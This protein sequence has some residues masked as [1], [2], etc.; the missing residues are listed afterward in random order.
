MGTDADKDNSSRAVV[1]IRQLGQEDDAGDVSDR[2]PEERFAMMWQ[3]A[4][5]AWAFKG[6]PVHELRL[7]RHVRA[8][9]EEAGESLRRVGSAVRTAVSRS[10]VQSPRSEVCH[11]LCQC[12]RLNV[13]TGEASG[14]DPAVELRR[15]TR[16]ADG[17]FAGSA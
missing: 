8:F 17:Q 4:L 16:R 15:S 5:D 7:P 14:T 6:E 12:R 13:C 10:L 3:L 1:R 9:S 2:T 11:W